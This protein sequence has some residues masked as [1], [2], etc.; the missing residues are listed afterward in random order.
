MGNPRLWNDDELNEGLSNTVQDGDLKVCRVGPTDFRLALRVGGAWVGD[1]FLRAAQLGAPNGIA[2]LGPTGQVP[3]GVLPPGQGG[4][5]A[6]GTTAGTA[7][8]GNDARL[9]DA[10]APTTHGHAVADITS[11]QAALDGKAATAHAHAQYDVTGLVGALAS[12][13]AASHGHALADVTDLVVTLAG[14]SD[15]G[16]THAQA[17]ITNL[18]TDL[19]A[20]QAASEKGQP[21]GYASLGADGKVPPAQLPAAGGSAWTT[22]KKTADTIKTDASLA[23]D[24]HLQVALLAAT[25]YAVRGKIFFDTGATSDFKWRHA[26]P[27]SPALVRLRRAWMLPGATAFAGIAVDQ[28]FSAAD[29][30]LAGT[31]TN[32]GY[33]EFDGIVLTVAAGT[34]A[35]QWAQNTATAGQPTTVRAGS[36]LEI[37]PI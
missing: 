12:K 28:A 14:K 25:R 22:V 16:H 35:I 9:S 18:T 2:P 31:G 23:T 11:L 36:Y 27:A 32:G 6:L 5:L 29:L 8:E 26:G 7:C 20:K 4:A 19:A 10:R 30:A 24:P 21:D 1:Y 3:T 34:F 13:A 17:A 15:V 33:V 37:M